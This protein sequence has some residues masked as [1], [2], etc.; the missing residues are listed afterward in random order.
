[1]FKRRRGSSWVGH[2]PGKQNSSQG[3]LIAAFLIKNSIKPGTKFEVRIISHPK[4]DVK[5]LKLNAS[6]PSAPPMGGATAPGRPTRAPNIAAMANALDAA[7][8]W[9][10]QQ[11]M[12]NV[13]NEAFSELTDRQGEITNAQNANPLYPVYMRS[14]TRSGTRIT[15]I[16][17][18]YMNILDAPT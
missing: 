8:S 1:M 17:T 5:T 12:Q 11:T 18:R 6:K 9:A 14:T 10:E 7:W 16:F 4:G 3:G 13:F 15:R 2:I